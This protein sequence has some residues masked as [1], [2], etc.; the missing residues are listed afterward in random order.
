[1]PIDGHDA[2]APARVDLVEFLVRG[3]AAVDC[4][5]FGWSAT[6]ASVRYNKALRCLPRAF[7]VPCKTL[8]WSREDQTVVRGWGKPS[9]PGPCTCVAAASRVAGRTATRPV[10]CS[11]LASG[12]G[13]FIPVEP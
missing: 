5:N 13:L 12:Q 2:L 6:D 9:Q 8:E 11:A 3:R 1:M 4:I 10:D 7:E